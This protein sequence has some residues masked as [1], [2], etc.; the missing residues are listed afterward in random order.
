M[1]VYLLFFVPWNEA[2]QKVSFTGVNTEEVECGPFSY[3]G[4]PPIPGDTIEWHPD[5]FDDVPEGI[6]EVFG[7]KLVV[8]HHHESH[9]V[10][11]ARLN[12]WRASD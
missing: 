6:Y 5:K 7:R 9:W 8:G 2:E 4:Q 10:V 1:K 3:M 11:S 12:P